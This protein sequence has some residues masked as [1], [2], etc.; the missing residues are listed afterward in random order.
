MTSDSLNNRNVIYLAGPG[1]VHNTYKYWEEGLYDPG[2]LSKT[3]SSQFYDFCKEYEVEGLIISTNKNT[4][5]C[6]YP[7]LKIKQASL[8]LSANEGALAYHFSQLF[9][10]FKILWE[11]MKFKADYAVVSYGT[12]WFMLFLLSLTKTKVIPSIHCTLLQRSNIETSITN[13]IINK[14][15]GLFFKYSAHSMM[16][17][18]KEIN[19]DIKNITNNNHKPIYEFLPTYPTDLVF[20]TKNIDHALHYKT[21][22]YV[23]RLEK[24]KGIY[25]LLDA[26]EKLNIKVTVNICGDGSILNDLK[27]YAGNAKQKVIVHGHCD[28]LKLKNILANTALLIVPTTKEFNEGFNKV[29]VEGMLS[30]TPVLT[31]KYCPAIKYVNDSVELFDPEN[32]EEL[33]N[34]ILETLT[35]KEKYSIM[36]NSTQQYAKYFYNDENSWKKALSDIIFSS[37]GSL[38]GKNCPVEKYI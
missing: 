15:N 12:H 35:D 34:L 27:K 9:Y 28:Q 6:Q 18:S 36:S 1:D 5:N 24:N 7:G 20:P 2:Q 26:A 16:T 10:G 11:A 32:I 30:T 22:T 17:V 37:T 19:V 14:L 38:E 25:S 8:A 21:L 13:K 31:T 23:G 29:I 3:Y 33:S 4:C